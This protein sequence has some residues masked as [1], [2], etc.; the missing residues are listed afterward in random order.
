MAFLD[1]LFQGLQD[2]AGREALINVSHYAAAGIAMG[3]GAM[4]SAIGEGMAA[5]SAV[6]AIGRQPENSEPTFRTMLLGQALSETPAIFSLVVALLLLFVPTSLE[7]YKVGAMFGSGFAIG[8]AA[9]G[10]GVGLG[11]ATSQAVT[12]V[13]RNPR[14]KSSTERTMIL[15][16]AITESPC[17]FAFVI[18]LVLLLVDLQPAGEFAALCAYVSAGICVGF[19]TVGSGIGEGFAAGQACKGAGRF[20]HSSGSITRTMILGQ[21]IAESPAVFTLVISIILVFVVS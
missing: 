7:I 12:N 3:L 4:G 11:T 10:A 2:E 8:A 19:G 13:A 14:T 20:P 18:S 16:M 17:V 5:G 1:N 9:I 21:A 6:L 15:G